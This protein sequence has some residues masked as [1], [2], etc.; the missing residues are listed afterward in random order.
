MGSGHFLVEATVFLADHVVYHST[1]RFQ[2][3][4]AKGESQEQMEISYWRRRV[5]EA[6]IYGVDLNPLA[7]E[8]AK[9]SLWLTTIAS[10]QPLNFLDHHLCCGNSLVGARLDDLSHVPDKRRKSADSL[11]L[12]WKIT[13]NLRAALT[14]AVQMVHNI[15]DA[16]SASIGDVK[17]KE[18]LWLDSV[19][20][21]LL[22]FRTVANLWT[23]CFFGNDLPQENYEALIE[24]LDIHPD[25]IRPW[26][27]AEEFQNIV[28]EALK[29]DSLTLRKREFDLNQLKNLCAFLIR[30]ERSGKERR[31]FHWEL[32]FPEVFFSE[33]GTQKENPGFDAVIGN[34]PWEKISAA[35]PDNDFLDVAFAE[36]RE[37]EINFYN[38]FVHHSHFLT[39]TGFLAGLLVPNTW[40]INKYGMLLRNFAL[41]HFHTEEIF[42]LCKGVFPDAP[43]TIPVMLLSRKL[44][45]P[46]SPPPSRKTSIKVVNDEML[47]GSDFLSQLSWQDQAS[48]I[49][50]FQRELHQMS[51]YDTERNHKFTQALES[52]SESLGKL[53]HFHK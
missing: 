10:D 32:E 48:E 5:V 24:L 43:D 3:E 8:L 37:G 7:V 41:T 9:L 30:S 34:P 2:A 49:V 18:K 19:R 52:V 29:K 47:G 28:T 16:S 26:K 13:E 23:A 22:P 25:K 40:L 42:Y 38:L 12:S 21:A 20:P 11:K 36:I 53:K 51:V 1:T 45:Q 14:K 33:D 27:S 15:E 31:F 44:R 35:A 39:G 6:C 46:Q 4:F 50:W 17:N